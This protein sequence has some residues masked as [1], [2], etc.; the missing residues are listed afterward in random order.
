MACKGN[1]KHF[2]TKCQRDITLLSDVSFYYKDLQ[3]WD[4]CQV[5]ALVCGPNKIPSEHSTIM[6]RDLYKSSEAT[7]M[8]RYLSR[9]LPGTYSS[10]LTNFLV[11]CDWAQGT[12]WNDPKT[13][14]K[15]NTTHRKLLQIVMKVEDSERMISLTREIKKKGRDK[16]V[17]GDHG[18]LATQ[19]VRGAQYHKK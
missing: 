18:Y 11:K 14:I 8:E 16:D 9:F 19:P 13:R 12:P 10:E 7:F 17:F 5:I 3:A 15:D 4:T 6:M 2:L 1:I